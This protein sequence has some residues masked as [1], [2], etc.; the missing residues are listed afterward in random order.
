MTRTRQEK[1]RLVFMFGLVFLFFLVAVARLVHL[2]IYLH[3]KYA[4]IVERQSSG[5]VAIPA[6]RGLVYDRCGQL[7][8]KN[9][10][11]SSLYA[12]PSDD[13]Q[14]KNVGAFLDKF[15]SLPSGEAVTK[16]KLE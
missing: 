10:I 3:D 2:Q 16:F 13:A 12:Y 1:I 11:G 4:G 8:A 6:E 5:R 15:L 14:V 9:V 7:V